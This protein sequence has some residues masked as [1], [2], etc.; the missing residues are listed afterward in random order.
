MDQFLKFNYALIIFPSL[1]L[2]IFQWRC[3]A[4]KDCP[5]HMCVPP[6]YLKCIKSMCECLLE[7]WFQGDGLLIGEQCGCIPTTGLLACGHGFKIWQ[8]QGLASEHSRHGKKQN[9]VQKVVAH[10]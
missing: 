9:L 5:S 6:L 10:E 1:F 4:D 3:N 8:K 2:V 7:K